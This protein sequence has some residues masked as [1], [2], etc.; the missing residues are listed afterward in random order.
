[1]AGAQ[2]RNTNASSSITPESRDYSDCYGC[3][4]TGRPDLGYTTRKGWCTSNPR[5]VRLET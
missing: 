5:Q 2:Y 1:M 3:G 4:T